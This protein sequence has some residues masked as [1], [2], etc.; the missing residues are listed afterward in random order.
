M[1][2][3]WMA[4]AKALKE[5]RTTN[6]VSPKNE[7]SWKLTPLTPEY[8]D[9]EHGVYV[10]AIN[11]ALVNTN[12]RNIALSG[13]YGVGKSSILQK[14]AKEHTNRVVE[15][16]LS[17]LAPIK[18]SSLDDSI[19]KQATTPTNL[20]QQEIVKQLLYREEPQKTPGSRFQRIERTNCKRELAIACLISLIA[21]I[22]F[23][24]TGW[25]EKITTES[26]SLGLWAHPMIFSIA[27]LM[28]VAMRSLFQGR[29][30]IGQL[31][32]GS[33]TVTLDKKSVSYFD[34]YLDEIVYFF[35]VSGRD[36]LLFEDIDRFDDA[37]IFETLRSLNT[38]LNNSP[39]IKKKPIRFIYAIK[40]SIFDQI[41]LEQNGRSSKQGLKIE[42][43]AEAEV[44]RANR[45][46]FFDVVIPVVP[47]ITHRSAKDHA[48][49]L[50]QEI[51][52][53]IDAALIDLAVRYVPDMRLLKNVRN[54][55]IVFRDRIF[56]GDG[57]KLN[58]S[59]TELFAM[60]LYK[61]THLADF[62]AIRIG[63]SKLDQLYEVS[64][65]LV[66][67][68][69]QNIEKEMRSIR[70]KLAHLNGIARQSASLG[71]KLIEHVKRTARAVSYMENGKFTFV[72]T[73]LNESDLKTSDFW[74]KFASEPGDPTLEWRN[75]N[76]TQ[77]HLRFTRSD[78]AAALNT[79]LEAEEWDKAYR[80]EL[81]KTVKE[82][83]EKL[84]F[85]SAA[86]MDGLIKRPEFLVQYGDDGEEKN[87]DT[88]AC[89]L[90]K[91]DLAYKLISAGHINRNFT[92]YTSTFRG[93]RVST[94]ATNFII[95]HIQRN[96]MDEYFELNGNDVDAVIRECGKE[97]LEESASYN[98]AIL[99]HLLRTDPTAAD[100]MINS[101]IQFGD[102]ENRF[103]QA[104]LTSASE[105]LKF[106][107]HFVKATPR[108]LM[109]LVSKV[110]LDESARLPLVS[111][112]LENLADEL[113]YQT[114]MAL[115]TYLATSYTELSALT[116]TQLS[117][118]VA[119][120][121]AK[122]FSETDTRLP[123]LEPLS[124][125]ARQAF[126]S[127]NLYEINHRNL[128]IAL[129]SDMSLSLDNIQKVN[130]DIY[131]YM[132]NNLSEYLV[133][134]DNI[135]NTISSE[136]SFITVIEDVLVLDAEQLSEVIARASKGCAVIN[137]EDVSESAWPYLA[138]HQRFPASFRNVSSYIKEIGE[139]DT[140]LAAVLASARKIDAHETVEED[141]K[142]QLAIAI[143]EA[144]NPIASSS[145]RVELARSLGLKEHL[146][147]EALTP[148]QGDLFALLIESD[149]IA[150]NSDCYAHLSGTDWPTREQVIEISKRFEDY[151]S[152][153]LLQ[154]D[155]TEF[156]ISN[157]VAFATK[158][159]VVKRA[160]EFFQKA[161]KE[162]LIE[163]AR[164]AVQHNAN[165]SLEM[166]TELAK[167]D[168]PADDVIVLLEP[169]LQVV[170][171]NQLWDI[172]ERLGEPY[173][174]LTIWGRDNPKIPDTPENHA[175][176]EALKEHGIVSKYTLDRNMLRVYK[177]HQP[178]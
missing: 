89:Q 40:D 161:N 150:D 38:L 22:I 45:T 166:I 162:A 19:P 11:E 100:M 78:L 97:V 140:H 120:R 59:E 60:M 27:A 62:E 35:E 143:L 122:I 116:S 7:K 23:F 80:E 58:L 170:P 127:L 109:Y 34:Q 90:L 79:S 57:A 119:E 152:P 16:S 46:K 4:F 50:L 135:S 66:A 20:I 128:V 74:I 31:S 134:I 98:I 105:Y 104:Y 126:V 117:D 146:D 155:L 61:S 112:A 39:Q 29:I 44:A 28:V 51:V 133:A 173:D 41:G 33:A 64:R 24:L 56:F 94:A 154:D 87:L 84:V 144:R 114:D 157:K 132:I 172:L 106:V 77:Q 108:S 130:E 71:N 67:K 113:V 75:S 18:T 102:K 32:A 85:L 91:S 81:E 82:L 69:I 72:S 21:T 115:A 159:A 169:H 8:I 142:S 175:L 42:D 53:Q 93:D 111:S 153:E 54:E 14:V 73:A 171:R 55:F 168:I 167:N 63:K 129:S 149:L 43:P 13:N 37:L 26:V 118:S 3:I 92:L 124:E 125:T 110:E 107:E 103:L 76:Y 165:L 68:N 36:I 49:Q 88:I 96:V 65:S 95:H 25:T 12:I 177:K 138:L 15:L 2:R 163:L 5:T 164:F 17:T 151:V 86:D 99:D 1:K 83:S 70:Q 147:V 137:L 52:H 6:G 47:F 121:I 145:I 101:L 176:L 178:A 9:S 156:L 123:M 148:E 158:I 174:K 10:L 48:V 30:H 141:E 139:I 160:D 136:S 131:D